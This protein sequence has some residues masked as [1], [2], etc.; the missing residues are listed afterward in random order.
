MYLF[1]SLNLT[2]FDQSFYKHRPIYFLS[3]VMAEAHQAEVFQFTITPEGIDLYLSHH[4]L[5][6][7]YFSGLW[8]RK[9]RISRI[10][11]SDSNEYDKT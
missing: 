6:Q 5:N 11:V 4:A 8:S 1:W 7:I 10:K 9:K 3:V 2:E